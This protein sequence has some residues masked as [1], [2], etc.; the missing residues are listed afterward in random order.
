MTR[1]RLL[2]AV[3]VAFIL[4]ILG[5][6]AGVW[7]Y[8]FGNVEIDSAELVP[9]N[10]VFF[11]SIPNAVSLL[12]GYQSSQLKT[13]VGSDNAKPVTDAIT[14][15]VGQ[16]NL[17]L[18]RT[19]LP[20]LSGQSF[21]AV[22]H[23]DY[24]HPD[25]VGLI[26]AMKPK[27]GLGDFSTFLDQLKSSY[28]DLL[29]QGTTGTG[30]V[31]GVDYQWIQGPGATN[32]ICVAQLHG[33]IV[34]TWGEATLQDWI[35]RYRKQSNTTSLAHDLDYEKTLAQVGDNPMTLLFVNN[36]AIVDLL[37]K[38]LAKTNPAASDYLAQKLEAVG[39][40]AVGTRFENGEI[41]DRFSFLYPRPAQVGSGLG[42][43]PCPFET[44]KFTGPDT[45][46]YWA[47]SIDW[48]QYYKNLKEQTDPASAERTNLN[49]MATGVMT[50]LHNWIHS[51]TLDVHQNV[52]DALGS[53]FSVQADW[54]QDATYPEVG[55]FVKLDKPDD[56]K[57]TIAAIIESMRQAYANTAVI[58]ELDSNGQK[59]ASLEFV[60]A[61]AISPTITED[62]PY[63]G[64]FLTANQAVRSFQRDPSIGLTNNADFT[65]QIG[66]KRNGASQ[67][68]FLDTPRLLD[69]AYRT[70]LPYLSLA[71]MFNKNL[72]AMLNGKSLP[73]DL[74]WL[75]PMGTWSCVIT[76]DEDGIQGYSVSGVGNQGIVLA[77]ALGGGAGVLQGMGVLPKASALPGASY[78]SGPSAFPM[79]QPTLAQPNP[80]PSINVGSLPAV[81]KAPVL[82]N[83]A[84]NPTS[85][86]PGA[87]IYVTSDSQIFFDKTQVPQDQFSDF[88]K[89]KKA[90][91]QD[92]Q[93]M[94][95]VDKNASPD[96]LSAVMDAGASAGFGVLPYTYT[97]G[98]DSLPPGTIV[99]ITPD[100]K[101]F[102]DDTPVPE[103]QF[104]DF[105][106]AKKAANQSLK[107]VV[108]VDKDASPNVLTA[109]MDAGAAAGF[110]VLPYTYT[111]GAISTPPSTNSTPTPAPPLPTPATNSAP[112][113]IPEQSPAANAPPSTPTNSDGTPP[114]PAQP[115]QE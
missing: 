112:A 16:K 41:V 85:N 98:V 21:I 75:A 96:I 68:L 47:S 49:P 32:K 29:R 67:M 87:I 63:L 72:A 28:P 36:H 3:G 70:A 79:T 109:V 111:S 86:T 19:F 92:L 12:A 100:G 39:G 95:H 113:A 33:W 94:V 73:P 59:F 10:T 81:P 44:L 103:D 51:T 8:L 42:A 76:P 40:M 52:V 99:Y 102:F 114:T 69:R 82:S 91:D 4:L 105:L 106:K 62:G 35:E 64:I 104:G 9:A 22:T 46:F 77:A 108:K 34:T 60:Q 30:T 107:L 13:L 14:N 56:F 74:T 48:K 1:L 15:A 5:L 83:P 78:F 57:P 45:R 31:E 43:D 110:G 65:R 80:V 71:Q 24:D 101:I 38:Q 26:A 6:A 61:S 54:G 20:N 58:K 11:A 53:E 25:Q 115:Q 50:F 2:L 88:L 27:A 89:T 23:F 97:S 66:D 55:L 37:Q 7:W 93:L 17:D 90:A 18:L 84:A